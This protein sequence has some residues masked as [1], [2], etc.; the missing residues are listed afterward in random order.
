MMTRASRVTSRRT[1]A[2][3]SVVGRRRIC[4]LAGRRRAYAATRKRQKACHSESD[5]NNV[6]STRFS[7]GYTTL[8]A[9]EHTP[10]PVF[11]CSPAYTGD[12]GK[13]VIMPK[14]QNF[15]RVRDDIEAL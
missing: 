7:M 5:R 9:G 13:G 14:S 4:R 3:A 2:P 12:P 8:Y 1:R 6:R 11:V 15:Q 10:M